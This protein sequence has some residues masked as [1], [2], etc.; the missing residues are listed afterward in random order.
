MDH[1]PICLDSPI[2]TIWLF[3]LASNGPNGPLPGRWPKG[4]LCRGRAGADRPQGRASP[5][6][7]A[8]KLRASRLLVRLLCRGAA[9]GAEVGVREASQPPGS[10]PQPLA[11]RWWLGR[12]RQTRGPRGPSDPSCRR[13]RSSPALRGS[14][15]P[16]RSY[17]PASPRL[18]PRKPRGAPSFLG[19]RRGA[20]E[21]GKVSPRGGGRVP[22]VRGRRPP[23][24]AGWRPSLTPLQ[25]LPPRP[26]GPAGGPT[27]VA[28]EHLPDT[29]GDTSLPPPPP[30]KTLGDQPL[31]PRA[32]PGSS[33]LHSP[34]F[35][36]GRSGRHPPEAPL[37]TQPKRQG[38]TK[39][40]IKSRA[41][42][43]GGQD[44]RAAPR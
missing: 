20:E 28:S 43:G 21:A 27:L 6:A 17:S 29:R 34:D 24:P 18:D 33:P 26:A 1:R 5:V 19:A 36:G 2:G 8:Q 23:A 40:K 4:P 41:I 25:P 42:N 14:R 22:R 10:L 11:P 37:P 30:L 7:G 44:V 39:T 32:R 38:Q 12:Y 13:L 3:E 15:S 31:S 35:S 16:D 9:L